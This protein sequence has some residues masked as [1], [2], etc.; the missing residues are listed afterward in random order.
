[1]AK[2]NA[3]V[4][5]RWALLLGRLRDE[6]PSRRRWRQ[7][8]EE[9]GRCSGFWQKSLGKYPNPHFKH[10]N[11][12]DIRVPM[13]KMFCKRCQTKAPSVSAKKK[14][15]SNGALHKEGRRFVR[16]AKGAL[17]SCFAKGREPLALPVRRR[18][19]LFFFS[20]RSRTCYPLKASGNTGMA[21]SLVQTKA[22]IVLA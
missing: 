16:Q 12:S 15:T 14:R 2:T 7:V 5:V 18:P 17:S 10:K 3:F 1:M 11:H 9:G 22:A 8:N 4:C 6:D 21:P 19:R 13:F 20:L